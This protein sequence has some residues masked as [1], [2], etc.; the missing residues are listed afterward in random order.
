M[1]ITSKTNDFEFIYPTL[2][3]VI[4][5]TK[6][7]LDNQGLQTKTLYLCMYS[8]VLSIGLISAG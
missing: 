3:A 6:P 1:G 5:N 4:T 8:L 7:D 2:K